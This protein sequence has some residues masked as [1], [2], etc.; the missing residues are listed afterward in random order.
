MNEEDF[1]NLGSS[2][3]PVYF[4]NKSE[5]LNIL[6]MSFFFKLKVQ[7]QAILNF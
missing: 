7:K 5:N 1:M 2:H 3:N 6:L 4:K